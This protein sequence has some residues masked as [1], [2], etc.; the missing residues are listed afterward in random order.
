MKK[1]EKCEKLER[2]LKEIHDVFYGQ[3]Y[4]LANYHLNGEKEPMDN[5]FE[6]N[7]WGYEDE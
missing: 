6:E 1:C 5:F 4:E 3:G 2:K 7:D